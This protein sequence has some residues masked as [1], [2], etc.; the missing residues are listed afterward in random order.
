MCIFKVSSGTGTTLEKITGEGEKKIIENTLSWYA[1]HTRTLILAST[2][3]SATEI[4]AILWFIVSSPAIVP[5]EEVCVT[6]TRSV[7]VAFFC[8]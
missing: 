4:Q 8:A 1:Y 2:G 7:I 5:R 3:S 6:H